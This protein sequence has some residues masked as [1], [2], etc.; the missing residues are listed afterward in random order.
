M[1]TIDSLFLFKALIKD[2][3]TWQGDVS[4]RKWS[5]NLFFTAENKDRVMETLSTYDMGND[6]KLEGDYSVWIA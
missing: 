4:H 5:E 3:C 2:G 6:Y 1:Q